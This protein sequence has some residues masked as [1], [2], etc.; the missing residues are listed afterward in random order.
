MGFKSLVEIPNMKM[1]KLLSEANCGKV[2]N[3]GKEGCENDMA[4]LAALLNAKPNHMNASAAESKLRADG[5]ELHQ[6]SHLDAW[7]SYSEI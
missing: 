7:F 2:N 5:Q 1:K 3:H 6:Q 4:A